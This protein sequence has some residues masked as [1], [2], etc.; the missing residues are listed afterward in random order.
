LVFHSQIS[1]SVFFGFVAGN[2][3]LRRQI[4]SEFDAGQQMMSETNNLEAA[5]TFLEDAYAGRTQELAV[6]LGVS[7][8][9]VS[10]LLKLRKTTKRNEKA[11]LELW[12][13]ETA[14]K[15]DVPDAA[16]RWEARPLGHIAMKGRDWEMQVP[17]YADDA[18][19]AH[20]LRAAK[21]LLNAVG[22]DDGERNAKA[23]AQ[24]TALD[25]ALKHVGTQP[26]PSPAP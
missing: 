25:L 10:V 14:S 1:S 20:A 19:T 2:L 18:Q 17:F 9:T 23:L 26:Q 24:K 7:R 15:V 21:A 16:G 3:S 12:K 22:G 11:V 4:V 8:P 5:L 13:Q 6:K